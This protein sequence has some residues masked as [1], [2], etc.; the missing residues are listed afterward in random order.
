[1]IHNNLMKSMIKYS[2][3]LLL[4]QC[5][6]TGLQGQNAPLSI[7]YYLPPTSFDNG[8]QSPSAFMGYEPGEWHMSHDQV[9]Y[10][11]K[12]LAEQSDRVLYKEYGRSHENRPLF[13]LIISSE[14]N[15]NNI[16][17][18]QSLH[19]ELAHPETAENV[20]INNLPTVINLGYNVHGNEQSSVSASV[21]VAYY[22]AAGQS[23]R[24]DSL[25]NSTIVLLDPCLN[26]DGMNRF[27]SW[28][29]MH[30]SKN[31][32]ASPASR[33]HNEI[34]PGGRSNHYWFD[35]NRD[36]LPLVHP[37]S[38]GR[39]K[40]F[41]E[42]YPN[43]VCDYHE[44]GTNS[45]YFFQPG[46]PSR[47]NPLTP[48]KTFELTEEIG[49]YHAKYLD[50][51]GS[52][53]YTKES[54]DDF[55]FGKG[56]TYP[57]INGAIGILFEQ[58]SSRGH[59][60]ES[61]FGDLTFA[62]TIR[63][64]VAT[65]LSSLEAAMELREPLNEWKRQFFQSAI[66]ESKQH[67]VKAYIFKSGKDQS[68]AMHFLNVLETHAIDIYSTKEAVKK[69]DVDYP[70]ASYIVPLEQRQH[71][72]IRGIFDTTTVF[73][74]SIFYD[75]SSWTIPLS[76]NIEYDLI[77]NQAE[78]QR[79]KGEPFEIG[80]I[81]RRPQRVEKASYAYII[82]THDYFAPALINTLLQNGLRVM[83]SKDTFEL[84]YDGV[85]P[86]SFE[87]GTLIIPV[88]RQEIS[89]DAIQEALQSVAVRYGIPIY[90]IDSGNT[91]AGIKL[92]SPS[93]SMIQPPKI[94]LMV[95]E[96][97]SY[98]E[99]GEVWHLLDFKYD[100]DVTLVDIRQFNRLNWD[101][102]T[103]LI[104]VSGSPKLTDGNKE[105]MKRWVNAG[106]TII[107]INNAAQW[108]SSNNFINLSRSNQEENA[109]E[110]S[111]EK[112]R[113][114]DY[115]NKRR[116]KW[117]SGA[118]FS[119][120]I[121]QT[122]P[123]FYGYETSSI[124]V[125]KRGNDFY[126]APKNKYASPGMYSD[127]ALLSG[128]MPKMLDTAPEGKAGITLHR[129]GRGKVICFH[130]NPLFRGYWLAGHRAFMNAIYFSGGI[131]LATMAQE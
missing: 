124:A 73:Q 53:Y 56:S 34:W 21:I 7:H 94:A 123:L 45:T 60:Q 67:P 8:I 38:Q 91:A 59:V 89:A 66:D 4:V 48:D 55:Y 9:V 116:S 68:K 131:S 82:E 61:I 12:H 39:V 32:N 13:H 85:N 24:V 11:C 95:G 105:H 101:E 93:V 98:T 84:K 108:L 115:V 1:M 129:S 64:Q 65:S 103:H 28:V 128:Y 100:I 114:V 83:F 27:S 42:W 79:I 109:E 90:S 112:V 43:V 40:R 99:C 130:D 106:G 37:E 81:V 70:A 22:L 96:G 62:F 58:A 30:K 102:Y 51:L 125:F 46:V 87:P 15:I 63:N 31:P 17:D 29:N 107:S 97:Y 113:Y 121:D 110:D 19:M 49:N 77:T 14:D 52:L 127:Q 35:L 117:M 88:Q 41:H 16:D 3:L 126:E 6:S 119:L 10:Y 54:F 57:D 104:L 5:V 72:L 25:L 26:P 47:N 80:N 18:L 71:R 74:D 50:A 69:N 78:L 44:M 33:E 2:L 120:D 111:T 20:D 36:W 122:H 76:M 23:R 86:K 75:V 92:G 118:I